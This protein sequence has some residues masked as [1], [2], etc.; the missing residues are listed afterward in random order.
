MC[1]V[2]TVLSVERRILSYQRAAERAAVDPSI[3]DRRQEF[4]Y[5]AA[6]VRQTRDYSSYPAILIILFFF[7][8]RLFNIHFIATL[9]FDY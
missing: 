4:S 2:C 6:A 9:S 3:R 1:I 8:L 5:L 7:V